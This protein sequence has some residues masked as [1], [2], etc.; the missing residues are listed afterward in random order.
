MTRLKA[1]LNAFS[2][3]QPS[4]S[5]VSA[6]CSRPPGREAG[7]IVQPFAEPVVNHPSSVSAT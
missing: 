1:L 6:S 2:D 3:S 7:M 5:A 4:D